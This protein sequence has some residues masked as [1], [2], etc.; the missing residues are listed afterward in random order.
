MNP[1]AGRLGKP[2]RV[3][4]LSQ[5]G[6]LGGRYSRDLCVPDLRAA[7]QDIR[8]SRSICRESIHG[9]NLGQ[10]RGKSR[11]DVSWGSQ[12]RPE[13]AP[14]GSDWS[15]TRMLSHRE[16]HDSYV[17]LPNARYF[18]GYPATSPDLDIHLYFRN[19]NSLSPLPITY[20]TLTNSCMPSW[21]W[22]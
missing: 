5:I 2:R 11:D 21:T 9:A 20:P 7:I 19:R 15:R 17:H 13:V 12:E 3:N 10:T 1:I 6:V 8:L 16:N 14:V 22:R 18:L 4:P